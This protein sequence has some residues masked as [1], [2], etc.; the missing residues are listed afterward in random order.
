MRRFFLLISIMALLLT[1]LVTAQAQDYSE[2]DVI[3]M[4]I[5]QVPFS[6]GLQTVPGWSAA[7][8]DSGN[9]YGIWRVQFW[10]ADGEEI[11][12]ANINP[13]KQRMYDYEGHFESTEEQRVTADPVVREFIYSHPDIIELLG[14][15]QAFADDM[16]VGYNGWAEAW[17]VWLNRGDDTLYFLVQFD[18]KV[19]DALTEPTLIEIGFPNVLSY[20]EWQTGMGAE[21]TTVAFAEPDIAAVLRNVTGWQSHAERQA[22]GL[23]QV[24]FTQNDTELVQA[25]INLESRELI[26]WN[27]P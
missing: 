11:G 17:G 4:V 26:E 2:Q 9:A 23:W 27:T 22:D 6:Y 14:D 7:A 24:T 20:D 19:P 1:A 21:A 12:W 25:V 13:A 8:Y 16:W 3:D 18:G 15:P 10:N 5:S